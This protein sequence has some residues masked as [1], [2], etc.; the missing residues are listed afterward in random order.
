MINH[1]GNYFHEQRLHRG[2]S[3]GQLARMAGYGN[4]SKGSNKI[5]RFERQGEVTEELLV[6]LADVLGINFATVQQLIKQDR[7]ERLQEWEEWVSQPVPMCLVV[8]YLPAVYGIEELPEAITTPEQ[9]E[10]W[11]CDYAREQGW[12]VCLAVSRRLSIWIDKQGHVYARTEATPD[13][14]NV[15]FMRVRGSGRRFL[16]GFGEAGS[17]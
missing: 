16:F 1:L 17:K 11:A 3:L 14:P 5:C 15:P 2:L 12:H 13:S 6:C 4:K 7:Q 10:K 8:K 9:A